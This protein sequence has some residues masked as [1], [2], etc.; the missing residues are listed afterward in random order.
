M[1]EDVELKT[2]QLLT[3]LIIHFFPESLKGLGHD[4][5]S[6]FSNFIFSIF[7]SRIVYKDVFK[8]LTKFKSQVS[9]YK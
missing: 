6:K 7:M 5:S 4:L 1:R 3:V 9:S 8:A 2:A